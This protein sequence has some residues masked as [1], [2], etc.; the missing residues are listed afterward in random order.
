MWS[1]ERWPEA[2]RAVGGLSALSM[3]HT[4]GAWLFGAFVV[5]H[6]YL[7]TTGRT[8]LANLKAMILGYEDVRVEEPRDAS[9][10]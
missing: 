10:S 9:T 2:V 5:M 8:P 3:I 1:G 7:T 4:F 6:V